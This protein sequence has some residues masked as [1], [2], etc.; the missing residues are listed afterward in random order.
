MV[1]LLNSCLICVVRRILNQVNIS[2]TWI[3]KTESHGPAINSQT[4]VNLQTQNTLNEG[5]TGFPGGRTLLHCWFMLL[6]FLPAFHQ[7]DGHWG[8]GNRP[9]RDY[10]TEPTLLPRPN[11]TVGPQA[12]QG[13]MKAIWSFSSTVGPFPRHSVQADGAGCA[14]LLGPP[15]GCCLPSVTF[16]IPGPS[17]QEE[18][19]L[20]KPIHSNTP[21]RPSPL[22]SLLGSTSSTQVSTLYP[23]HPETAS[24]EMACFPSPRLCFPHAVSCTWYLFLAPFSGVAWC[25]FLAQIYIVPL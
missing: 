13:L 20:P 12:E 17:S 11:I 21:R 19:G 16:V 7:K 22:P 5:K 23:P 1:S 18:A 15:L 8:R 24:S 2:L 25:L 4:W 6:I 9:F 14:L 10:W 3:I